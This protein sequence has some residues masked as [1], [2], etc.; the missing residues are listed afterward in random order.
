MAQIN[1]FWPVHVARSHTMGISRFRDRWKEAEVFE[2]DGSR[3]GILLSVI[4]SSLCFTQLSNSNITVITHSYSKCFH[5][6]TERTHWTSCYWGSQ[7]NVPFPQRWVSRVEVKGCWIWMLDRSK[8]DCNLLL[9]WMRDFQNPTIRWHPVRHISFSLQ[10]SLVKEYI[11]WTLK[12]PL[13]MS[14]HLLCTQDQVTMHSTLVK[15][16]TTTLI[17]FHTDIHCLKP[18]MRGNILL[19][20]ENTDGL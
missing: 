17:H 9:C 19:L 15:Y 12:Q 3:K 8:T 13:V 1:L 7:V 6:L 2:T 4:K 10:W 16:I 5:S 11:E 18:T 20:W 14:C